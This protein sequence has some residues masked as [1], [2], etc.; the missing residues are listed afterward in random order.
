MKPFIE[1]LKE[2]SFSVFPLFGI[3]LLL[4]FTI[5]PFH[6]NELILFS[7]SIFLFLIGLSLFNLGVNLSV[8]RM[9]NAIGRVFTL[10]QKIP[11]IIGVGFGIGFIITYADPQVTVLGKQI[12]DASNG[13]IS[14]MLLKTVVSMGCGLAIILAL[15]RVY[16][17]KPLKHILFI[18]Y[19]LIF[20]LSIILS[21]VNPGFFAVAMDAG[22]VTTGPLT[23]P[24]ILSLGVG[25]SELSASKHNQENSFGYVSLALA[26]PIIAVML[27]G[28]IYPFDASKVEYKVITTSAEILLNG[29]LS[30]LFIEL[31]NITL[32]I[33][34][35]LLIFL[36]L[37]SI[38]IRINKKQLRSI[39]LGLIYVYFGIVFFLTGVNNGFSYIASIIGGKL[40][41]FSP[42]ILILVGFLLGVIVVFAEPGVW[43]LNRNIEEVSGGS[44]S[45]KIMMVSLGLAVGLAVSLSLLRIVVGIPL[46]LILLLV[47]SIGFSLMS[48]SPELFSAIAF[49]SGSVAT[50]PMTATFLLSLAIGAASAY[51]KNI[52]IDAFGLVSL[53]AATPIIIIQAIGWIVSKR[54][55]KADDSWLESE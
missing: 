4:H 23:V 2:M 32:S 45:S 7:I 54:I 17:S 20:I 16:Y 22:G 41:L 43:V 8:E 42:I 40:I 25:V 51:E 9:G 44:I 24:F 14:E 36:I 53:V 38:Y 31:K 5:I 55:V 13:V 28:I 34:P 35:V 30:N 48:K 26:G 1:K 50:G 3:V 29:V 6:I 47:Y 10:Q 19:G 33:I 37:N 12:F 46:W 27:L 52:F 15:L 49:D 18:I 21:S 39:L 11:L